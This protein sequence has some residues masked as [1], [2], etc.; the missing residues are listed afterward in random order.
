MS[1]I[2]IDSLFSPAPT[3][4]WSLKLNGEKILLNT[5]KAG[6]K[7][8][9]F[10]TR[11]ALNTLE[12]LVMSTA[13]TI[14]SN[15]SSEKLSNFR[16][17]MEKLTTQ[18]IPQK[19]KSDL[20]GDHTRAV[21]KTESLDNTTIK[22]QIDQ[23]IKKIDFAQKKLQKESSKASK[24]KE[25]KQE[26]KLNSSTSDDSL[27]PKVIKQEEVKQEGKLIDS[28]TS[29]D[30]SKPKVIKQEEI[31]Q[32]EK[33]IDSS[34]SD[35]S[36]VGSPR[37]YFP[38][39]ETDKLLDELS[40]FESQSLDSSRKR[41]SHRNLESESKDEE[42][43]YGYLTPENDE[44]DRIHRNLESESEDEERVYG[45]LTPENDE[46]D[47]IHRKLESEDEGSP[48][49]LN[50]S[51]NAEVKEMQQYR[52]DREKKRK[53]RETSK[54]DQKSTTAIEPP[55]IKQNKEGIQPKRRMSL[56]GMAK[57]QLQKQQD[58]K[59][60]IQP[61]RRMSLIGMA[62]KALKAGKVE[63]S[64]NESSQTL[65]EFQSLTLLVNMINALSKDEEVLNTE[66][67]FR[68][69]G[70]QAKIESYYTP[71]AYKNKQLPENIH[72]R[73]GLIKLIVREHP[74]ISKNFRDQ[75]L[76]LCESAKKETEKDEKFKETLKKEFKE[77]LEKM[78]INQKVAL[79]KY[80]LLL[81]KI[82]TQDKER[83]GTDKQRSQMSS[84]NLAISIGMGFIDTPGL[85]IDKTGLNID[86]IKQM[87]LIEVVKTFTQYLIEH[88]TTLFADADIP[89][90]LQIPLPNTD[91][92]TNS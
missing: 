9:I 54:A 16:S 62:K 57:Q 53:D 7:S 31:K 52:L 77:F 50:I 11:E 10:F 39:E 29:D 19:E 37:Y 80:F 1:N 60:K 64:K 43:V 88:A 14:F 13:E 27:K 89:D 92:Q 20:K 42:S 45:Y 44:V 83:V 28:S 8:S 55:K 48:K 82:Y 5:E 74:L 18:L 67:I 15:L 47:R 34:T 61:K 3:G 91:N 38:P 49:P 75:F 66:G 71:K 79:K 76:T 2:N 33:L 41:D 65:S 81:E 70:Q 12:S 78:P 73:T 85:N 22:N 58:K 32:E 84:N 72:D 56:I 86:I 23:I 69:S 46:V 26:G 36:L 21:E 40:K 25:I 4:N 6:V 17:N 87:G 90:E 63:S 30:S 24:S 68:M 35:G 51:A 59:E